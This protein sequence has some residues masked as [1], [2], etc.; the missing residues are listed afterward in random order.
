MRA[1][2]LAYRRRTPMKLAAKR[3]T[4]PLV[5]YVWNVATTGTLAASV[6]YQLR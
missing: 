2:S 4:R 1:L 3:F 6:A 5:E